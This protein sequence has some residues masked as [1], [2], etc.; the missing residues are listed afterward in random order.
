MAII[1]FCRILTILLLFSNNNTAYEL[2]SIGC[3]LESEGKIKEAIEY[4]IKAKTL[5]PDSPE[6][7]LSLANAFYKIHKFDHGINA[8]IQGLSVSNDTARFYN[9]IAI[10]YIGKRDF[11]SAIRYYEKSIEVEP[12]NVE[13][14]T[15]LSILYEATR[16]VEKAREILANMPDSLKTAE[17]YS[18]L[19][20]LSGKLKDHESAI[21]YYRQGYVLDTTNTTGLMGI[22]TGFDILNIKDSAIYYYEKALKEDTLIPEVG[23]RL[24]DLYSDTEQYGRL[25]TLATEMLESDFHNGYMRR[26]LGY[27]F[28]KTG[29]RHQALN[30]FLIASRIDPLD[31]YSRFYVGR[32]YM[33]DGDYDKAFDE[34]C[35]AIRINP[36]FIE[37]WVYLGF[38]AIEKKDLKTAE[39]AFTEAAHRGGDIV[40]I[41]YLL[42]V[43]AEMQ[44]Q[45][46]LAYSYYHRSLRVDSKNIA[47]LEALAHLC[48]R[49]DKKEEAFEMFKNIIEID[50]INAEALNYVGYT[51]AERNDSLEYAL[52]LINRALTLEED[53]GYYIDSRGWVFYQMKQYEKALEDLKR[54]ATIIEDAVIL[55]HLGDVYMKLD[56]VK[57]AKDAY[58]KALEHDPKNKILKKKIQEL[59]K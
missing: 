54:A 39:Y 38:V 47:T 23:R 20:S 52:E 24:I 42:G 9:T 48:E 4:Y 6:I 49:I 40:Q 50:T 3:Y 13:F 16:D 57:R 46:Y 30:E 58:I 26:S 32:M 41:Y 8:A 29:M 14:Y 18:Q 51:F 2:F 43:I 21:T 12:E 7:Y 10:G 11:Q 45:S 36:D 56:D 53:N 5:A 19:G 17:V 35:K 55:E 15:G 33:E 44:G 22:G 34:I 1:N 27:A 25:I 59:G 28:Y 37:L 31:A